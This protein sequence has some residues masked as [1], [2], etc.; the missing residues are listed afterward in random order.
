VTALRAREYDA[1]AL[2][3]RLVAA[4]AKDRSASSRNSLAM[5]APARERPQS[6]HPA[7]AAAGTPLTGITW[8]SY[9]FAGSQRV[10]VRVQSTTNVLYYLHGDHLGST[11]LATTSG[12]AA[13]SRQL[14]TPWGESRWS[15]GSLPT[16]L[17][18][19]GQRSEEAG[20]GSLYDYGARM[21]SPLAGR[22]LSADTLVPNPTNPQLFN[23]YSYAGNNPVRYNDPDGH[24]GPLCIVALVMFFAGLTVEMTA[25]NPM[26][27]EVAPPIEQNIV[28]FGLMAVGAGLYYAP[29][30][31]AGAAAQE[32]ADG[33]DQEVQLAQQVSNLASQTSSNNVLSQLPQNARIVNAST[34]LSS[35]GQGGTGRVWLGTYY[36]SGYYENGV[37]VPYENVVGKPGLNVLEGLVN[38]YGGKTLQDVPPVWEQMKAGIDAAEEIMF[39]IHD[40]IPAGS[41]TWQELQ[42]ILSTPELLNKT[43]F[44]TDLYYLDPQK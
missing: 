7:S 40:G 22:F 9:Y 12:A 33:D 6:G 16:D 15:S 1:G 28:G 2:S 43:T 25:S 42:Y 27:S 44:I 14:Y 31:V 19:T 36:A 24:C 3:E 18:F 13:H 23:R 32:L 37:Q 41:W 10:A 30:L 35:V 4:P 21:Y 20:L 34:N 11:S 5:A 38:S 17:R 26:P 8:R 29:G 39:V